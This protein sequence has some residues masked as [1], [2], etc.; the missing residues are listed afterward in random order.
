[1]GCDYVV[2][3]IGTI[4]GSIPC[5]GRSPYIISNG[6]VG[7]LSGGVNIVC[8]SIMWCHV[9]RRGYVWCMSG[10]VV[11]VGCDCVVSCIVNIYKSIP[12]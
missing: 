1:M 12:C 8:A 2:S 6:K 3:C 10:M 5:V 9:S 4:Y 11:G 7:V